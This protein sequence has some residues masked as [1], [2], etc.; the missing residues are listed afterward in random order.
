MSYFKLFKNNLIEKYNDDLLL[1]IEHTKKICEES[2]EPSFDDLNNSLNSINSNIN[3]R[4]KL[5]TVLNDPKFGMLSLFKYQFQSFNLKNPLL[6]ENLFS[7]LHM[8]S[9]YLGL[10]ILVY[11]C[12]W[13]IIF[14]LMSGINSNDICLFN[15]NYS[16]KVLMC[17][18]SLIYFIKSFSLI[19]SITNKTKSGKTYPCNNI[20]CI[21]DTFQE[22]LFMIIIYIM[23]LWIIFT[24]KDLLN[25]I[26]NSIAMDFIMEL[27]NEFQTIYFN[28]LPSAA[29]DIY[30]NL[31]VNFDESIE[32]YND[33]INK[34]KKFN[35]VK[36]I[37]YI[38]FKIILFSFI[39]MPIFSFIFI[40]LGVICK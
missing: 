6:E 35:L 12:Q 5:D 40:W 8:F 29:Y 18:I 17:S 24:E 37:C 15:G 38:P 13:L 2:N 39:L 10:P 20:L 25:M 14:S 27:D 36:K 9:V 1:G 22:F 31:F 34:S 7:S 32:L 21:I 30:D 4:I 19:D 26:F 33:I 3:N 23:N 28:I 11:I 16:N